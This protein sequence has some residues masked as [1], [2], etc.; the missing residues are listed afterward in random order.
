MD[1]DRDWI[2]CGGSPLGLGG[3]KVS[4]LRLTPGATLLTV[5]VVMIVITIHATRAQPKDAD[6]IDKN[7]NKALESRR[8]AVIW[9]PDGIKRDWKRMEQRVVRPGLPYSGL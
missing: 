9:V 4:A 1:S 8:R 7:R 6:V 3:F 5:V 2:R